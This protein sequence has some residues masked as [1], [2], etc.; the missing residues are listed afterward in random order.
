MCSGYVGQEKCLKKIEG[1]ST[2][3]GIT[4]RFVHGAD[5]ALHVNNCTVAYG[6]ISAEYPTQIMEV[7]VLGLE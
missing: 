6:I 4:Q 3:L 7:D 5:C 1:V 2:S